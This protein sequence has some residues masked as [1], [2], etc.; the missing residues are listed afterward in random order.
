QGASHHLEA[1]ADAEG[2]HAEVEDAGVQRR[3]TVL[4]D[5]RGPAG[6]DERD[7]VLGC[8]LGG[9]DRVRHDLAV[10][11]RLSYAACD[12]LRVLRAEVDDERGSLDGVCAHRASSL[13]GVTGAVPVDVSAVSRDARYVFT[14][15]ETRTSMK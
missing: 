3:R 9:R 10:H 4:V 2:R 7:R 5:G 1:V 14:S 13:V 12:E 8:D 11:A 6:E 15:R